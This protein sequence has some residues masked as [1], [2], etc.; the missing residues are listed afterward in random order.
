M[1]KLNF[2]KKD[3]RNE[4]NHMLLLKYINANSELQDKVEELTLKNKLN[5]EVIELLYNKVKKYEEDNKE[6]EELKNE[7]MKLKNKKKNKRSL[8]KKLRKKF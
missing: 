3:F 1:N 8:F 4:N 5:D 7:I 2:R 6:I